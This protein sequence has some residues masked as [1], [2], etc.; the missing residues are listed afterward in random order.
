MMLLSKRIVIPR[1]SPTLTK[2]RIIRF[3]VSKGDQ[4]SAYDPILVVECSPDLVTPAYRD[5]PDQTVQMVVDTQ[6]DGEATDLRTDLEGQWLDVDTTIG[7]IDDGDPVDGDWTW[8]A[9]LHS[10]D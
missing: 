10:E 2:A 1:L 3:E 7:T 4:V 6:D 8:Q 9:N 5:S